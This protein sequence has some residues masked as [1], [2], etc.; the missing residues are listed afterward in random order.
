[1]LRDSQT[2]EE[3]EEVKN[4]RN[5]WVV[6]RVNCYVGPTQLVYKLQAVF[7][8][9]ITMYTVYLDSNCCE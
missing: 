8:A 5:S 9:A 2:G 7:D 1:M 3:S 4:M 6:T